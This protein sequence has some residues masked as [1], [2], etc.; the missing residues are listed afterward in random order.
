[1]APYGWVEENIK[2]AAKSI[3]KNKIAV[4]IGAYGYD[5]P[6]P[7]SAGDIEYIG[8]KEALDRAQEKGAKI[9]WDDDSQSPFFTYTADN[10]TEHKV[11]FEN[12]YS[13]AK[14]IALAKELGIHGIAIWRMGFEDA[15]YWN[16]VRKELQK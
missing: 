14:K 16:Q 13:A 12:G 7:T 4:C 2:F 11:W 9:Q 5:W 1:M 3:P 15:E 6:V 10:G 8:L